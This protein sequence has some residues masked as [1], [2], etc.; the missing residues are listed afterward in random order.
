MAEPLT[1]SL[2]TPDAS[3]ALGRVIARET[4]R[5]DVILL[6][7]DLGA[8]KTTIA[9]GFLAEAAGVFDAPSPTYTLVQSY[10]GTGEQA[11]LPLLHA[12]LY[13]VEQTDELE[14]LGLDEAFETGAALVEWPDRLAGDPP[15]DRL[16]I[17]LSAATDGGR[18]ARL[19]AYG[20][21]EARLERI[22]EKL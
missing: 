17:A 22:A 1:L 7:G 15:P 6:A 3:E 19:S 13:R 10:D 16:E 11:G 4:R 12:D 20:S 2:A 18:E 5:G 9:R 14:E 8:G 21:W